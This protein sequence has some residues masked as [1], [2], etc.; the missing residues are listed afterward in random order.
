M[1]I[2]PSSEADYERSLFLK[3]NERFCKHLLLFC[4]TKCAQKKP[5]RFVLMLG[6][7]MVIRPK[8]ICFSVRRFSN[9][10]SPRK[11][12]WRNSMFL[13]EVSVSLEGADPDCATATGGAGSGAGGAD[14]GRVSVRF[15]MWQGDDRGCAGTGNGGGYCGI[16]QAGP[17]E[18]T[19]VR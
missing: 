18:V 8:G 17:V 14:G 11:A 4:S 5:T 9:R 10:L 3:Y 16:A 1:F 6:M 7:C 13:R 12:T 15:R 2:G 19:A